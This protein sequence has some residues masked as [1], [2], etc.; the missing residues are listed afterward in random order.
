MNTVSGEAARRTGQEA[1][2]ASLHDHVVS[3]V[4]QRW[5]KS[6]QC[7][8]TIK[9]NAEKHGW[10]SNKHDPD[11]MGWQYNS[12]GNRIEWIAE[13]ET[14]ESLAQSQLRGRLQDHLALGVPFY[15]FVPKGYRAVAQLVAMRAGASLNGI[16][17]Y[18]F[19]NETFQ[20]S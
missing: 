9:P 19:I 7:K 10:A 12:T 17:E 16:Y 5:A 13:V 14:E 8:V 11:I 20:L 1:G 2:G 3:L 4:A 6:F 18:A 15:L